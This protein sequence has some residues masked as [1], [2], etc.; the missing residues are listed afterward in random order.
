MAY[1]IV[2]EYNFR[3]S[4]ITFP[5]Q[6]PNINHQNIGPTKSGQTLEVEECE[7]KEE[8]NQLLDTRKC[9]L[10]TLLF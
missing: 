7:G 4:Y 3:N 6:S 5:L 10:S 2:L 1:G 9:S 8:S